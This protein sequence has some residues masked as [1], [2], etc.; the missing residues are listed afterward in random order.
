V[1]IVES[2]CKA[3]LH[4]F[5][6]TFDRKT[7][8]MFHLFKKKEDSVKVI[9]R[10]WMSEAAKWNGILNLWKKD[11]EITIIAWFNATQHHLETL[12]SKET[13][14]AVSLLLARE[15][16]GAQLSG[17]KIIFAEHHPLRKKEQDSFKLWQLNEAIVHS[18]LDESLFQRFGGDKIIGMMKQMGMQ[19]D[20][21]IEHKMISSAIVNA[22]EKIEG[23]V[24]TEHTTSSQQEW[25]ERNLP[26]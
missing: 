3:G 12:F 4:F 14:S 7:S 8:I 26:A 5:T 6:Y 18:A 11:P 25:I 9:D 17:K 20:S 1:I 15:I 24:L 13:T 19:E 10:I 21:M 22:Q 16:H 2:R 23:K